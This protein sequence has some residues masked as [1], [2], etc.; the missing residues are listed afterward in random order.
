MNQFIV[1]VRVVSSSYGTICANRDVHYNISIVCTYNIRHR[2]GIA[3]IINYK[4]SVQFKFFC[5]YRL[6]IAGN[7]QHTFL[8]LSYHLYHI[9]GIGDKKNQLIAY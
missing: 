1:P 9:R 4:V 3:F 7:Y 6:I 8:A 5:I 2:K